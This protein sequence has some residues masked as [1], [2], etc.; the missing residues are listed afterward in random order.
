MIVF[1]G[2][3][4][5]PVHQQVAE[6]LSRKQIEDGHDNFFLWAT[7]F[8]GGPRAP[9]RLKDNYLAEKRNSPPA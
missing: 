6:A 1:C 9:L 2:D 4:P 8:R 5:R 7:K 3:L